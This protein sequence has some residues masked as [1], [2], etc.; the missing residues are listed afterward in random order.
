MLPVSAFEELGLGVMHYMPLAW[1][2]RSRFMLA[3]T[4]VHPENGI[5]VEVDKAE[6]LALARTICCTSSAYTK[7]T[8]S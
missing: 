4:D 8:S 2:D 3:A 1:D 5:S 6:D 7:R